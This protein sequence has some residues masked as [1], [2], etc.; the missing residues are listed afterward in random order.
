MSGQE[1]LTTGQIAE[2]LNLPIHKIQYYLISRRID[3]VR[4][5]GG[6]R[7]FAADVVD[8][9]RAEINGGKVTA[10]AG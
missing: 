7:L 10:N 3:P 4:R 6:Y 2:R 5:V 9:L 1:L 8:K